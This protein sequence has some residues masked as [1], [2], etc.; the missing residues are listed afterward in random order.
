MVP[1]SLLSL[2]CAYSCLE[3]GHTAL[4]LSER[5]VFQ[6]SIMSEI[7][8]RSCPINVYKSRSFQVLLT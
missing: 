8:T 6:M 4:S 5:A 7:F 3:G 1:V 2:L